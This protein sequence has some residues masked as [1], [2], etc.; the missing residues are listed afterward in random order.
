MEIERELKL[1]P[2]LAMKSFFLFGPRTTGK[3]TLIRRQ[4]AKTAFIID[5]LDSRYFLRLSGDPHDLESLIAANPADII[6]IDEIQRIPD[7]LNEIHRL[8]E[9]KK[10]TFLLTGSSA[11]K[12]RR[13]KANLL[14]GRV[15]NAG[16]FP[17]IYREVPDFDLNRYLRYGG[18]PGVYLSKHPEEELDAYVNTY[19]KEEI[20]AEGLIRRLP[21]FSR[22]LKTI[23]MANGEMINFTKLANDSQVPPSTVTEYVGLLEDT[24]IGF[25]LP[26]WSESK[27][28]KA[29]KT[30]KFY[31]FDPGVTHTGRYGNAGP[32]FKPLRKKF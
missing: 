19:L 30:G 5:L 16:M 1:A 7:L 20:L 17:L 8:I 6:V 24:L 15:W 14:A 2:L 23:A 22:F 31:F 9:A 11:R 26:A 32:Q 25:L 29:I 21:P 12:L 18:L 10:Q 13:G 27:K 4:L 28:R 3:T